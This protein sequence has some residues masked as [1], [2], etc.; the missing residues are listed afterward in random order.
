MLTCAGHLIFTVELKKIVEAVLAL[1]G[2]FYLFDVD[3]PKAYELGLTM[4]HNL[5]FHNLNTPGDL[6]DIFQSEKEEYLDFQHLQDFKLHQISGM[7]TY[8]KYKWM[9][10]FGGV[11]EIYCQLVLLLG[12]DKML[13]T[14]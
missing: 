14:I 10:I 11:Y 7:N 2:L 9:Y 1:I 12:F 6:L 8:R 13:T 5:V 3:Y 4:I